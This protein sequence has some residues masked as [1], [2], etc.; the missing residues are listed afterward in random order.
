MTDSVLLDELFGALTRY[1]R[2]R[3]RAVQ[4]TFRSASEGLEMAAYKGLFHLIERPMRSCEL[5]QALNSDPSTASRHVAQLVTQGLV[6]RQAD[7][8]DGRATL[9]VITDSGRAKADAM[10]QVRRAIFR[11]ATSDWT[12]HEL[13]TL[14]NLLDRLVDSIE[15]VT[16]PHAMPGDASD[17]ITEP[18]TSVDEISSRVGAPMKGRS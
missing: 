6:R 12:R 2:L 11:D 7:P 14:A 8:A 15:S 5:A 4:T 10:R 18:N 9:L 1:V 3:E 17:A 13:V 16:N